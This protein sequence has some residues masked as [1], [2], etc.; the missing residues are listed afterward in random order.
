MIDKFYVEAC[1]DNFNMR[2]DQANTDK[3]NVGYMA[4]MADS[5]G[6]ELVEL[7]NNRPKFTYLKFE[8]K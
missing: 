5:F 8:K 3:L 2:L 1:V 7:D 6:L 4:G